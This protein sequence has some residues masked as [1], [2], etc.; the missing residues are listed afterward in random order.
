MKKKPVNTPIAIVERD[1]APPELPGV[2]P[3]LRRVYGNRHVQSAQQLDRSLANLAS[4]TD[5][6]QIDTAASRIIEAIRERQRLLIVGDFDA[7]GATSVA[8][9]VS[10]FE[11]F[12]AT[13]VGYLVPN[14][15]EF[16]YGLSPEIVEVALADH[17]KVIITVDNGISSV[18]GVK[19]ANAHG[20][21]VIITDHHLPGSELPDAHA[22]VNPNVPDCRF[23]SKVIAGVGVIYY[24]L[25]RVRAGLREH[26]WFAE[27][28]VAEPNMADWL[29]LVALGTVADVVPL[30]HNNRVLIHQGLLR[31]RKGRC[32]PGIKALC[33][34]ARRDLANLHASDLAFALGPRL[35]AAGRLDDMRLGIK[36]LLAEDLGQAR[37]LAMALDELNKAR[38]ELEQ[39]MVTDA[40]L[41]VRNHEFAVADRYGIAVF[42]PSWH[43]GVIGI[44]AGRLREK[45]H[46]PVIAFAEAG[47]HA[48]G[49]LKGSARSLPELHIRDAL[50]AVANRYPGL[51]EKFGGHAMAAGLSIKRIHYERFSKAFDQ[52][53][54]A[55]LPV[56]AL[57]PRIETDGELQASELTLETAQLLID[58]GPWGQGFPEPQ[59]HGVFDLISQ[60]VVG[61]HHLKLVLRYQGGDQGRLLDGIAFRQP[62]I[63]EASRVNIVYRLQSND[64]TGTPSLQ[65]LVEHIEALA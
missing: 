19:L 11:A 21:D 38:R 13:N 65:L 29:D 54:R 46:R 63:K 28:R 48:P 15:F 18:A 23:P 42:D 58:S 44:V 26:G 14:R 52:E 8:L 9:A 27:R 50:E 3:L 2:P 45:I 7:D 53:V 35:N 31:I 30:D 64:Y 4:P 25:S 32:R 56:D 1:G 33:E 51:L 12:G 20:V 16:G 49:E 40:E 10:L 39:D 55:R 5:M 61:E 47:E 17:P 57:S 41:I 59:F 22:I 62:P 43:Q 37:D 34:I 24:V 6:R 60:R 36:C